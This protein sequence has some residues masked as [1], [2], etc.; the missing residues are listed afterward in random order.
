MKNTNKFKALALAAILCLMGQNA[1]SQI[2]QSVY[3]NAGIPTAQF[4]ASPSIPAIQTLLGR[5]YIGMDASLGLGAG[6]RAG[7]IFDIGYGEVMPF[8]SADLFWN[9]I[10]SERRDSYATASIRTPKYFNVPLM[11]GVN[12]RYELTDIIT[13]FGEIGFGYDLTIITPEGRKD[14]PMGFYRYNVG[15]STCWQIGAGSYFGNHFS[16]GIHYYGLGKHTIN[17]N[18]NNSTI[19]LGVDPS[20]TVDENPVLRKIGT[21]AIR[22]GFHF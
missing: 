18:Y 5:E 15:G 20:A 4:S 14:D 22:L 10:R 17:Y 6:Y 1:K 13:L 3:L 11:L 7:Y 9:Q 2:E 19:G 16:V 8:L 21:V 12:Y